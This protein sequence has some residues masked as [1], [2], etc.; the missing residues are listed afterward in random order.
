M[1]YRLDE[2]APEL[3]APEDYFVADSAQ[4][5]GRVRLG[6]AASIWFNA[7][8]R[9]DQE[10]SLYISTWIGGDQGWKVSV[11]FDFERGVPELEPYRVVNLWDLGH[12]VYGDP[13][14]P[15]SF[16]NY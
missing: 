5:I 13:N 12:L 14:N 1:L 6:R 7:V 10:L 8:L 4:V 11:T 9:G 15:I 2:I 3:V 16:S